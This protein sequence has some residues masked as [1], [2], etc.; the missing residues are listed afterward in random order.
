MVV[1]NVMDHLRLEQV[2]TGSRARSSSGDLS[3]SLRVIERVGIDE[4][5]IIDEFLG[6]LVIMVVG[7]V[8]EMAVQGTWS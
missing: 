7:R 2:S 1:V 6:V 3:C 5:F 8:V 4:V